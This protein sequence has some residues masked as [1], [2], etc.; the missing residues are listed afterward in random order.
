VI[1]K[2]NLHFASPEDKKKGR[3]SGTASYM[4]VVRPKLG[5]NGLTK[6]LIDTS[7][8]AIELAEKE[9]GENRE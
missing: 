2:A 3:M 5:K 7:K 4:Y 6:L 1:S 8:L 9:L